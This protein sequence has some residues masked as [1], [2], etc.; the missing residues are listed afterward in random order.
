MSQTE[1]RPS[2][3]ISI[4]TVALL[5]APSL[6]QKRSPTAGRVLD[7]AGEPMAGAT[8]TFVGTAAPLGDR[9]DQADEVV[10]VTNDKG[11]FRVELLPH[12]DYSCWAVGTPPPGPGQTVA[13]EVLTN[14]RA[15]TGF[16]LQL[17]QPRSATRLVVSGLEAWQTFGPLKL[18]AAVA[19]EH[20]RRHPVT[21]V[22]GAATLPPIPA[23]EKWQ[24]Y[25]RTAEGQLLHAE[26]LKEKDDGEAAFE[27]PPPQP[28]PVRVVD[29]GD[30]PIADAKVRLRVGS[31]WRSNRKAMT[32]QRSLAEW[33][34]VGGT[35]G[36]G[37][38]VVLAASRENPFETKPKWE[39]MLLASKEGHEASCSGWNGQPILDGKLAEKPPTGELTFHLRAAPSW[40]GRILDEQGKP[41]AGADLELSA[42]QQV[43]LDQESYLTVP[44]AFRTVTAA[45]GSFCFEHLPGNLSA[46]LLMIGRTRSSNP[47]HVTP[48][49]HTPDVHK[50]FE[51]DLRTLRSLDLSVND[52][53]GGPAR[54]ADVLLVP[55]PVGD[56]QLDERTHRMQLDER[57]KGRI[58][59]ARGKWFVMATDR[60]GVAH[61][62]LDLDAPRSLRLDLE[63][64]AF[65]PVVVH[66]DAGMAVQDTRF[67]IGAVTHGP[68]TDDESIN[69]LRAVGMVLNRWFLANTRVAA[70]GTTVI[71]FLDVP[72]SRYGGSASLG[73]KH[74]TLGLWAENAPLSRDI[75]FRSH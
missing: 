41:L 23:G 57:G 36:E 27:M 46:P 24:L 8:V 37:R 53:V 1:R 58:A 71:H 11:R 44:V 61:T 65:V 15:G 20:I 25:V 13:S 47:S 43:P 55:L 69:S 34:E 35:D 22:D 26:F 28:I 40:R 39:V 14:V 60:V 19:L 32:Q 16:E 54:G 66:V 31:L 70:D 17:Q 7:A 2:P 33:R 52:L 45:D 68:P 5:A 49:L 30:R 50:P 9:F 3:W 74:A 62:I 4:A 51:L 75:D 38:L 12:F 67:S 18:E 63:P 42:K 6:A 21:L 73:N 72:E 64:L 59:V 48:A 10:V 29:A 56:Q